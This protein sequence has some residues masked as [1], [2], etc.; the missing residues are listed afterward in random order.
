MS[1]STDMAMYVA[2][3]LRAEQEMGI[4]HFRIHVTGLHTIFTPVNF[5]LRLVFFEPV[6][7]SSCSRVIQH[8]LSDGLAVGHA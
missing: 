6:L 8:N 3:G 1:S 4:L 7:T 5:N 2:E